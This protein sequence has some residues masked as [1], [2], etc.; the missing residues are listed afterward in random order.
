[1]SFAKSV[2]LSFFHSLLRSQLETKTVNSPL[3]VFRQLLQFNLKPSDLT[4]S[5]VIKASASYSLKQR[6]EAYQIHTHLLKSG[7]IHFVY[8]K[9][10]LLSFYVNLGCVK[11]ASLLLEDMPERDVVAW[12]ALISG[13]S[14]NGYDLYAFYLFMEM[15]RE[16]FTPQTT[17]LVG[18]IPSI[19]RLELV[20][21]GKSIHG[22]GVKAGLD[23]DSK[24]KNA[25]TS[26]YAKCRDLAAAEILFEEMV[27]KSVVTW[28]TMIGAYGQNGLFDE[29]MVLFKKMRENTLEVN[30]VTVMSLLSANADHETVHCFAIKTGIVNDASVITSLVCVYARSGDNES[31]G[32]LHNSLPQ[33]NLVSLTAIISSYAERGNVDM[34]VECFARSQQL[35]M[36]LDAVAMVGILHG[37]KNPAYI[38]IG[39][40]FHG[41]GI[42]TGLCIHSL[43]ANGL[44]SMYSKFNDIEAVFSLFS[45]MQEKPLI[46]WNSIIS[47]CVQAGR[48]DDAMELFCR[49]KMFGHHPDNIT[50]ASLLSGCSQL[51]YLQFGK[52]LHG[53]VLRNNLEV[54]DFIGTAL[55]DM[56]IKCGSIDVAERVFK[57]IKEPCLATWNTMITGYGVCGFQNKALTHY[58]KLRERGL[59]PDRITLLGVLAACIHGGAVDEGR[60]YFQIMTEEFGLAPSLQHCACMVALLSRA[61]LF[62]EALLF[63]S[64]MEFDPDS[65]VWGALLSACCTHQEVKLGEYIA[66]KLYLLDH[67][68]GGLYVLMSNLYASKGM[69]DDVARVRQMMKDTGGDG[70]S[71]V[72]LLEV[73]SFKEMD[74]NTYLWEVDLGE[75]SGRQ[76]FS[77]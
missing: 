29:A 12:N 28:N 40:S 42:K 30:S 52:K 53:F 17:T 77:Y 2:G 38:D 15:L 57:S 73:T 1:M 6:L 4:F 44:I 18:L 14:K 32:L 19:G 31:A 23:R 68:N 36:E 39:L 13:Y 27:E 51:G 26:M 71:G 76:R 43:V 62:E 65:T 49:M 45:E 21:Q 16:G 66:K 41:Y 50:I 34:V 25:L 47:G 3:L 60:R 20:S 72:S 69:W 58:A 5:L 9:T 64:N 61:R 54:E 55:I 7:I 56:Y 10:T 70:C 48:A 75:Q 74:D 63:I 46:S 24:V 35:D 37:V 33:E 8:I 59:K 67:R 11:S 22:I